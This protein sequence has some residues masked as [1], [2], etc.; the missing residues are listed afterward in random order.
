MQFAVCLAQL[1]FSDRDNRKRDKEI[2][3]RAASRT[4]Y[5]V[6][7]RAAIYARWARRVQ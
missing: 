4:C 6:Q 5:K 7:C 3:E 1:I 2:L